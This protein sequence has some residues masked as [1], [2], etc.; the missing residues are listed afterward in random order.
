[1]IFVG[2]LAQFAHG[3]QIFHKSRSDWQFLFGQSEGDSAVQKVSVGP[4]GSVANKKVCERL[5]GSRG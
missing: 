2:S 1:M 3:C 4:C 5:R